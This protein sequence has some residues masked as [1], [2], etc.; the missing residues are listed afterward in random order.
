MQDNPKENFPLYVYHHGENYKTYEFMG[1]HKTERDGKDGYV[2]R[3][4]AP[5]A[6]KVSVVGDFNGW[7]D[8]AHF[9]EKM[10]D[11]ETFEAFIPDLKEYDVYK[12]CVYTKDGRK[13]LKADPYAYH[14]ETPA[15]TASKLYN[16]D[17]YDWQ[18]KEYF[19]KLKENPSYSAPMNI[20][21]VNLL[22]WRLHEDGNYY[23][24]K[25]LAVELVK[26]V[27]E[28]GYTHVEFMPVCEHPFDG[29]WGYQV[30]GYFAVT[31][32]LGTPKDFMALI[33]AFHKEGI[34]VILDWV[35]AHFPKDAHGLYEFDGEPLYECPQWDR[36]EHRAWGTRRFDYGRKEII[37]FLVSSAVFFFEKYHVDGLRVDAVASMLY[38]DYDR[39]EGEWVPNQYGENKNLEAVALFRKLNSVVFEQYPYA[40]MIAEESTAWPGVTKPAHEGG[41]GFNYKWNMGW[42]NDVLSYQALNPY[43]RM[44]NHDKMTFA[45]MYAF[46]ENYVLPISHDEVVH[47][48]CSLLNKMPGTNEEKFA[49]VKAFL[50][51]M[52]SHPGKKLNF[53]GYEFGQFKEWNYKEGLEFF[54]K[55][56]ELHQKLSDYVRDINFFYKEHSQFYEIENSW[57]GFEWLAPDDRD[58]N[59]IA[60]K[61]R[62]KEG[63]E[64]VVLLCFSG[65]DLENYRLGLEK[66]KYK[67]VF[68]SDDKKYGG[69]GS[70]KKKTFTTVK[71]PSHGKE[72]SLELHMPKLSCIY[73]EK[74]SD[75]V[76]KK[77]TLKNKSKTQ[78]VSD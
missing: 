26:Y 69:T 35:P 42:M 73:L 19:K 44:N 9:M 30:T 10:I 65:V 71:K 68:C 49:G 3:V 17:G 39:K 32:R 8:D 11:G 57:D 51:Y 31:S 63:K 54:L 61:R 53:M 28:M 6:V 60:Y 12:Y 41:L 52:M 22:S 48:K 21:E 13:L 1:S 70:F 43:F 56:Y 25:D 20:Y 74:V 24:Y 47:G 46:S 77:V 64:I 67:V 38:L 14:A 55:D 16:L 29:S 40:L 58:T 23:S 75:A 27:K 72:H 5:H 50:G 34:G 2:F 37:S 36:M 59:T 15:D 4:W 62:N 76:R 7:K 33:D 66:G 78:T 45:M 18:D